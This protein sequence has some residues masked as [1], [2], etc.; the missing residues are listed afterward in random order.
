MTFDGNGGIFGYCARELHAEGS[1]GKDDPILKFSYSASL[2]HPA[3]RRE[4]LGTGHDRGGPG[5]RGPKKAVDQ[6]LNFLL[7]TRSA[8]Y[9]KKDPGKRLSC[10]LYISRIR[11]PTIR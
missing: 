2:T 9:L 10:G 5:R 11:T 7:C 3:K 8:R 6:Q 4:F 1:R